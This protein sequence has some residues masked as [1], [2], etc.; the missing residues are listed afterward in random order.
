M[1]TAKRRCLGAAVA[2]TLVF[3]ALFPLAAGLFGI[4]DRDGPKLYLEGHHDLLYSI[5]YSLNHDDKPRVA[6]GSARPLFYGLARPP[7]RSA[8]D[9]EAGLPCLDRHVEIWSGEAEVACARL[10]GL[11]RGGDPAASAILDRWAIAHRKLEARHHLVLVLIDLE[12]PS[13][14]AAAEDYLSVETD[15]DR[16]RAMHLRLERR[17]PGWSHAK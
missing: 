14:S 15:A 5:T 7:I 6:A 2:A 3:Y 8:S 17:F 16:R 4:G 10:A 12:S 1:A 11:A 13:A 9:P